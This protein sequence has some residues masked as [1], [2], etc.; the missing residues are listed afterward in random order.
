M[1][2]KITI[3]FTQGYKLVACARGQRLKETQNSTL[4]HEDKAGPAPLLGNASGSK[5][6]LV[7]A[8][9]ALRYR[10]KSGR[11]PPIVSGAPLSDSLN[12]ARALIPPLAAVRSW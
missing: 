8:A 7:A 12:A 10:F 11:H 2:Q 4:F 6:K 5:P 1:S 9:T 3:A